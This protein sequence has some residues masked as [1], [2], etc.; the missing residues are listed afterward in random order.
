MTVAA[1]QESKLTAVLAG[2]DVSPTDYD[3]ALYAVRSHSRERLWV[4]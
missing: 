3:T 1:I 2:Y 4:F